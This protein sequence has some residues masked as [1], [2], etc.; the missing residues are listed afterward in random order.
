MKYVD[1]IIP[2]HTKQLGIGIKH[3][4]LEG[5]EPTCSYNSQLVVG[6]CFQLITYIVFLVLLQACPAD[7]G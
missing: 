1:E 3:V 7:A 2:N 6:T 4:T 5:N